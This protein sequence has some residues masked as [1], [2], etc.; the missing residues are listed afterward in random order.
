MS[1]FGGVDDAQPNPI[2]AQHESDCEACDMSIAVG[3]QIVRNPSS[4]QFIHQRCWKH[5]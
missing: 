4:N 2:S 1:L 3:D 5:R